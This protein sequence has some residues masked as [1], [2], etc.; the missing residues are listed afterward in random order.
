MKK[1]K[2]S[3]RVEEKWRNQTK[4]TV[5]S[6]GTKGPHFCSVSG[7]VVHP[8]SHP[9]SSFE[10]AQRR[11]FLSFLE[12][13]H[14]FFILDRQKYVL[15]SSLPGCPVGAGPEAVEHRRS[16][17]VLRRIFKTRQH[18]FFSVDGKGRKTHV[19]ARVDACGNE[20]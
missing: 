4:A 15:Y 20:A 7:P 19:S 3:Q 13:S 16:N 17:F 10:L 6:L 8:W 9:H 2:L 12:D 5:C 11:V 14:S 18:S 1:V